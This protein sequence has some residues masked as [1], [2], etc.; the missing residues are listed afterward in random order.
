MVGAVAFGISI[1]SAMMSFFRNLGLPSFIVAI[2]GIIVAV[3]STYYKDGKES[4]EGANKD[5]RALEVGA[6][7]LSGAT[8]VVYYTYLLVS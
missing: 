3:L 1:I 7:I 4:K 8:C 2:L 5:S 6:I